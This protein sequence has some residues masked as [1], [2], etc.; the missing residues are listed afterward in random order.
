M[1]HDRGNAG[2]N[3]RRRPPG[4]SRIVTLALVA[5]S[6]LCAGGPRAE[7]I[8][9][10]PGGSMVLDYPEDI[11][12]VSTSNPEIVDAVGVSRRELL[13]QAKSQGT[14]TIIVWAKSGERRF[15]RA[16]VSPDLEPVRKLLRE[17]FPEESIEVHA[18][19]DSL[20][21]TGRASSQAVSDR[22]AAL[23]APLAKSV[24]NHLTIAA[25]GADRQI[26]LRVRFA[27]L[28]RSASSAL[29]V[30]VISTGALNTPARV[31]TGQFPAPSPQKIFRGQ[32][33]SGVT[34]STPG[35]VEGATTNFSI[36][37]ALN[38]FA[39]RPDLNLGAFIRALQN[40][41]LLQILAEPNLVTT[42]GKEASFLAGGEFPV[43]IVQGGSNVGAVTV[44]FREFG[45]RLTFL[46]AVTGRGTIKLHVKPEVSS[47]DFAN[48][49]TL[50]GFNIPGLAV[51]RMETHI[52]LSEGQ[53][54]VIAGLIDDRLSENLA[55][56]PGLASIPILGA[57]FKS[58]QESRSK[59]ELVVMVTPEIT[60]P[61][62][63]AGAIKAPVMQRSFLPASSAAP[64][65][66]QG[67]EK[68]P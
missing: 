17:T 42:D 15:Y 65:P 31:T 60:S 22:A 61:A 46:P 14:A 26:L 19:R 27:E 34:G 39:F 52:E 35:Q 36:S 1:N 20:S 49:V 10:V 64:S 43:P 50:S 68:R 9:L 23:V 56:V 37:D 57:L 3:S 66:A 38:I 5:T 4:R 11:G 29:G 54:F 33:M 58:R 13:L 21:L 8:D 7:P 45:I 48:G 25:G 2:W 24:V 28:N 44:Q 6:V 67:G 40:R 55:R 16:T 63:A 62:E 32:D 53:S 18:A 30:N 47:L 12:R 51:R 41:G 59:T